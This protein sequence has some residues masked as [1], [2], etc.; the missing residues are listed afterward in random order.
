MSLS[1]YLVLGA[2]GLPIFTCLWLGPTTGY[3]VGFVAAGWLVAHLTRRGAR[4]SAARIAL[5][6]LAGTLA[7]YL[8][9]AG[10]LAFGLGLGVGRAVAVGVLPFLVGDALKLAAAVAFVR[11]SQA[12]LRTLFP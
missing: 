1:C 12:R 10:W 7:I 3:L 4:A 11:S 6:M 9:G 2:L 8:F 5:A